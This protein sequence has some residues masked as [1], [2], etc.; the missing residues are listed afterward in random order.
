MSPPVLEP[1]AQSFV[2]ATNAPPYLFELE[3]SVGRKAV[4]EVQSPEMDVPG[5]DKSMISVPGPSG[6]VSVSIFRPTGFPGP[7]PV[8]IY[9]HG[10]G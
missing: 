5:T 1:A 7:L 3:P 9:I 4:D 8:V 10:A 2:V 6:P